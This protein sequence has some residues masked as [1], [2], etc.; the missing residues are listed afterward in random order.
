MFVI[1]AL[2]LAPG[3]PL[4]DDDLF[5]WV[6]SFTPAPVQNVM[7]IV[8]YGVLTIVQIWTYE[9]FPSRISRVAA[10]MSISILLG[11]VLEWY[12]MSVPGRY[13]TLP[14]AAMNT[15]GTIGGALLSTKIPGMSGRQDAT[16]F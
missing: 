6:V 3:R 5:S 15:L 1:V 13:G 10:A 12:Q 16:Q 2:S 8:A 11:I 4:P 7:H 14:D 9:R